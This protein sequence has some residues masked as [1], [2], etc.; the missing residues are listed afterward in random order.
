MKIIRDMMIW[1][2]YERQKYLDTHIC[3]YVCMCLEFFFYMPNLS[4][5]YD[6]KMIAGGF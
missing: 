1:F 2:A 6:H 3:I 5:A 4:C